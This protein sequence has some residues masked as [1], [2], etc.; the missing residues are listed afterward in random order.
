MRNNIKV[1]YSLTRKIVL[2][3]N[4]AYME[5]LRSS[6]ELNIVAF[7]T[8]NGN[9]F[10]ANLYNNCWPQSQFDRV[11]CWSTVDTAMKKCNLRL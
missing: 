11:Q 4:V 1:K 9:Y 10:V 3:K 5:L 2:M 6:R 7:W 8:R